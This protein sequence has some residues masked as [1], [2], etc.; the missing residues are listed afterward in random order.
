MARPSQLNSMFAGHLRNFRRLEL[1]RFSWRAP[2]LELPFRL[3]SMSGLVLVGASI[4]LA[5]ERP[6]SPADQA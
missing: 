5:A 4:A 2:M 1:K 3:V 6:F